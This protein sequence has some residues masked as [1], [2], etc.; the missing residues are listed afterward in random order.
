[1]KNAKIGDKDV[2][3]SCY[4]KTRLSKEP[5]DIY[6]Q[7]CDCGNNFVT[8]KAAQTKYFDKV[9]ADVVAGTDE[10][11]KKENEEEEEKEVGN[12]LDMTDKEALAKF[13]IQK[14]VYKLFKTQ[15]VPNYD[16]GKA[17]W[18][19]DLL[20]DE[21]NEAIEVVNGVYMELEA[22]KKYLWLDKV[23]QAEADKKI[24]TLVQIVMEQQE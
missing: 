16:A 23:R 8:A 2:E 14:A 5:N 18:D 7:V 20:G 1:M 12:Y 4:R 17:D 13:K 10:A 21:W 15:V 24:A 11:K 6:V 3:C 19:D 22:N 9:F